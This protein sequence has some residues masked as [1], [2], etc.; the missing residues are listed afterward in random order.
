MRD[1][2]AARRGVDRSWR[3]LVVA[4]LVLLG[5]GFVALPTAQACACGGVFVP[6]DST[7]TAPTEEVMVVH[8]GT[9]ARAATEVTM[10]L[11]LRSDAPQ[12][13]L[14]VP[15]P[16]PAQVRLG[17][18][19]LFGSLARATTPE[20]R[21]RWH[22]VGGDFDA[23]G[24][25]VGATTADA[26]GGGVQELS[27]VDLGPLR[28]TTLKAGDS[29]AL[30]DWLIGHGYTVRPA[31]QTVLDEYVRE[32]WAFVAMQLTPQGARLNGALPPI[33]L[34]YAD[35]RFVY[36]MRM[37]R[38]AQS[39]TSVKTYVFSDHRVQRTDA[40]AG[41]AET[42][43]AADLRTRTT[44]V[45]DPIR[46]VVAKAL[47]LTVLT[48]TF[49]EPAAQ[50][51]SDFTF[52]RAPTDSEQIPIAYDDKYVFSRAEFAVVLVAVLLLVAGVLV[53][54][55]RRAGARQRGGSSGS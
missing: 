34:T 4:T 43:F 48:Q 14:V 52:G 19:E 22:L 1:Y 28:A 45:T 36:P 44:R 38:A 49:A 29:A 47:Y 35:S 6:P 30:R 13:G 42:Y 10:R 39:P 41:D 54:V 55:R 18:A 37:S 12:A 32:G 7:S 25:G 5:L 3:R 2:G 51:K 53:L 15:T 50:V 24:G 33:T 20:R 26:P 46:P 27:S 11:H 8:T 31:V 40:S 17:D 21:A 16:A 23:A 9:G